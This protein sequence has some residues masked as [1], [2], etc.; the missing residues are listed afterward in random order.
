M[1][2]R[3]YSRILIA[4]ALIGVL[5][6]SFISAQEKL[7]HNEFPLS[8]V[9]LLD[10]PFKH[11]QDLN[12]QVLLKYNPDRFLAPYLKVAGLTPKD[13]NYGNWES[14]GLDG[15]IGG[16]YLSAMAIH[17]ASTRNEEFKERMEYMLS[18]LKACQEAN[19]KKYPDW[20]IGYLGGVPN[21]DKLWPEIKKGNTAAIWQGWVPM[22][23]IHKMY[24]GLRDAWLYAGN[25]EAKSMFLKFCDWAVQL[26]GDLSDDQVEGM[27]GNEYGG[28]N[29]VF[30]DAYQI[31]NDEKY[32][33]LAKR[34]SHKRI[35][36]PMSKGEDN[37]DNMHANT[38]VPKAV[39]FQR[40]AELSNDE[41]YI[42]GSKYFWETVVHN[43]SI[44]I[45]GNSR[46]EFFPGVEA[47]SD[48]IRDV[49]GPESCNTN[50]MLKLTEGL[51][52]MNPTAEYADYYERA[53][54][55]HILSTQHPDHGGYVYFTPA[56]PNHYR[57]YSA[58]NSAMW[59][60]VGT[61]LENH[62]KY[63]QFIY[64]HEQ[65]KLFLNLFIASELNWREKGVKITQNTKFPEEQATTLKIETKKKV[66][67]KLAV[68][69]PY[70]VAKEDFKVYVNGK[71][72]QPE[73]EPSSYAQIERKWKNGDEVKVVLPM[74]GRLE[75]LIH[76]PNYY[77]FLYGPIVLGASTSTE[78]VSGLIADDNRWAHIAHG[79]RFP[80][81][82]A[83]IIIEDD[84]SKI[85]EK[86]VPVEGKPLTFSME[87]VNMLNAEEPLMLQ[88][89]YQIHDTRYM[90]YWFTLTSDGYKGVLDSIKAEEAYILDLDSRTTDKVQPGQQQ[91]E[92]DHYMETENS[93][94]GVTSNEFWRDARNGG[95]FSYKM[96]TKGQT[97]LALRLR[98]WG[99]N[100][101]NRKFEIYIDDE[102]LATEDIRKWNISDFKEET[103]LI[104]VSMLEG[105][106]SVRV[107]FQ[108]PEKGIAGGI[109]Y[110]RLFKPKAG[111]K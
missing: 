84:F 82:E 14:D 19:G 94:T 64:A 16:H 39:G 62:G 66:S 100:W 98:Y 47:C 74:K 78:D 54:Y 88:P 86:L 107:K 28:L 52:R 55:N 51:F 32:L 65:D 34:F 46:R 24:A 101:N 44:A 17:Y 106:E 18:E 81:N 109:F 45:G 75:K 1:M 102:L 89:F 4:I 73:S 2:K 30:A 80:L 92:A 31:T 5:F 96:N 35:L 9:T 38:Q 3:I 93:H 91:P 56:R 7:Y 40:V 97:D 110:V 72:V 53:M 41:K 20:G 105:K 33:T 95:F 70:W 103:Y 48:Y 58:P 108:A 69:H 13:E 85:P 15:H 90:M 11:A 87:K 67:F 37:L 61:G 23:N 57:V 104:P 8:D 42:K 59:C 12:A 50:N 21:S 77:A 60:C 29:E 26:T 49:E 36:D 99:S 79:K 25:E 76:V 83:P 6:P 22:Y 43:R 63:G 27:L 111:E 71:E 68:R 10:G